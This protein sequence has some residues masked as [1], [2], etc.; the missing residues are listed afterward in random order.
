MAEREADSK[1]KIL[2]VDDE[3][4]VLRAHQRAFTS[5]GY[6]VF[7]ASNGDQAVSYVQ[8]LEFD[9]VVSDIAMPMMDGVALLRAIRQF[10]LDVPVI[11]ITGYPTVET[12]A[13]AVQYGAF[14]YLIKPVEMEELQK[15]VTQASLMHQMARLKRNALQILGDE[16]HWIGD[17]A[18]LEAKFDNAVATL[19]M[20]YQPIVS[21]AAKSVFAYEALVRCEESSLKNPGALFNSAERLGRLHE[22][23][24]TIRKHIA[25]VVG[26]TADEV[27]FFVNLHP[28]D[29][30][31]ATLFSAD[32]PL[33]KFSKR[34]VFEITERASL[35]DVDEVREKVSTLR[36]LGFRVAL[37]DLGA[38]YAGL[39]SLTK[40]E[41]EIV[42]LDMSIVRDVHLEPKKQ[43]LIQSFIK[44]CKEMEIEFI[45]EGIEVAE[46]R[47]TLIHAGC[48]FMQGFFFAKPTRE[49]VQ[50]KWDP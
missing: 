1:P 7:T 43:R 49:L 13:L 30:N 46:E 48:D 21:C 14:R 34:V 19:W 25:N 40:L 27:T 22:L 10:D 18:G 15:T 24:R 9:V 50:L 2:L 3:P 8:S 23:G 38:G 11:L 17:L 45:A 5:M 31:D 6:E 42:K 16:A 35:D 20:A 37:D 33:A 26:R 36:R 29:L 47:D 32:A 4:G 39:T 44:L 41:P 12:A 28:Q